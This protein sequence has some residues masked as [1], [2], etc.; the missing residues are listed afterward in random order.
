MQQ[1][2][3]QAQ[4]QMRAGPR[5]ATPFRAAGMGAATPAPHAQRALTPQQ[6]A[7][8][9][10]EDAPLA[11][12]AMMMPGG[13]GPWFPE[14]STEAL[15]AEVFAVLSSPDMR[16]GAAK[17][18]AGAGA[19]AGA[20]RDEEEEAGGAGAEEEGSSAA[21]PLMVASLAQAKSRLLAKLARKQVVENV[22]PI[23][24]GL[25]QARARA[26]RCARTFA[27][28]R[29]AGASERAREQTSEHARDRPSLLCRAAPHLRH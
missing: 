1:R 6:A 14:G 20:A 15:V 23:C 21:A 17:G 8:Q 5:G 2:Q 12:S 25:K 13:G 24:I 18:G 27:D 29:E 26:E 10:H 3:A 16:V 19:G 22:L 9:A 11:A 4:A 28:E 7:A